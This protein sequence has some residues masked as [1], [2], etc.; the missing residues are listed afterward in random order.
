MGS[1]YKSAHDEIRAILR[2]RP[3]LSAK[4]LWRELTEQ[5]IDVDTFDGRCFLI[6]AS[7]DPHLAEIHMGGGAGCTLRKIHGQ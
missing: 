6:G 2:S 4:D 3:H 5:V 7:R 1:R